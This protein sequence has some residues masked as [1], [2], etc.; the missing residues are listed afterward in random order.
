MLPVSVVIPTHNRPDMLRGAIESVLG[1]TYPVREIIV[2]DN[3]RPKETERVVKEFGVPIILVRSP[4]PGPSTSRNRGVEISRGDYVAFLDDDD[5]WH[6]DKL[7]VQMDF[8]EKHPDVAMVSCR[9]V[10][11][12]REISINSGLWISGDLYARLFM[13]SF[14]ATPTVVVKKDVLVSVGG[15]DPRY[16]R[17]EDYDLWLRITDLFVT[18]HLRSPLA[19]FRSSPGQLSKNK[20][21][22]R[23]S[24]MAV[25][26]ERYNPKKVSP[27]RFNRRMSDVLIFLGREQVRSGDAVSGRHSF[28]EAFRLTPFRLRPIRYLIGDLLR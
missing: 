20:I 19:W 24:A 13:E 28:V 17:A 12:G 22:L 25:L 21:D 16:M 2:V 11:F 1:Q 26:R 8:L 18:A 27:R 10:P 6:P 14:V 23:R 9:I 5:L 15:F 3:G 7:A 4:V